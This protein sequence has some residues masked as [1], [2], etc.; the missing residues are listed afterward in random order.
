MTSTD[1]EATA[2]QNTTTPDNS[3]SFGAWLKE[4]PRWKK[5]TL[6]VALVAVVAGGVFSLMAGDPTPASGSGGSAGS[7]QASLIEGG[8]TIGGGTAAG[9]EPASKGFFRIGFSFL[10]GFCIGTFL[11]ATLKIAAIAFGFWLLMTFGLSYIGIVNVDWNAMDSLWNRFSGN[12][13][14]EW[15]NFQ[16][17]MLGSL[18]ATGLAVTGLAV[19]L[20][21]H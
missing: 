1:A 16:T 21:R 6:G 14:S 2:G 11:R 10:A 19:G 7:L 20:K 18:P 9:E 17:F 8:G 5:I 4:M 13:E 15:G 3:R 12:V